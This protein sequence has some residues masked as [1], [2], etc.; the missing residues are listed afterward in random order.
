MNA[1]KDLRGDEWR[2]V[3]T[4]ADV[5]RVE[6]ELGFSL[7][8]MFDDGL[9]GL[10]RLHSDFGLLV[11][12]LWLLCREQITERGLDEDAFAERL[13]GDVLEAA[14]KA[15]VEGTIGFFPNPAQRDA[16]R[17][18]V[19]KTREASATLAPAMID[20]LMEKADRAIETQLRQ[21]KT[22]SPSSP[23]TNPAT[24]AV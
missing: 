7:P 6:R 11:G 9:K 2:P 13:G 23:T 14:A 22:T 1:F 3:V 16:M 24:P 12:V 17:R 15:V 4:Y 19:E 18:L 5:R 20:D 21:I 8:G 10:A